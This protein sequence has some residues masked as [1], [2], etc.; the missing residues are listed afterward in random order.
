MKKM[1]LPLVAIS[2]ILGFVACSDDTN[3]IGGGGA[4]G[5]AEPLVHE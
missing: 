5:G 3:P 2:A 4:N 1:K